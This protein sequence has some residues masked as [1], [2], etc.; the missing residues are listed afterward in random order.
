MNSKAAPQ[1]QAQ[2]HG[3]LRRRLSD[4]PALA[5]LI[6]REPHSRPARIK[7]HNFITERKKFA[8]LKL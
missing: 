3:T 5:T 6:S 4:E 7:A 1:V 2:K 8:T